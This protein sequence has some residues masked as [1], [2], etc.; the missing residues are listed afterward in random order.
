MDRESVLKRSLDERVAEKL[1][2][3]LGGKDCLEVVAALDVVLRLA[4]DDVAGETGH[5]PL[6]PQVHNKSQ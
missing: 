6:F 2:V 3:R 4:G 5:G 1:I